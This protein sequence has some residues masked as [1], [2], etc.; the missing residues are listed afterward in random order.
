[1][2]AYEEAVSFAKS[3][4][5]KHKLFLKCSIPII[6]EMED[7][8]NPRV[9]K[10]GGKFPYL[11]DEVIPK[12]HVCDQFPMM[13]VQLY[14]PSLPEYIQDLFPENYKK[15]LLV[16]GVCPECLGSNW[17]HIRVYSED[18]LDKLVY[19]EDEGKNWAKPEYHERRNFPRIPFS[20]QPYDAYDEQRQYFHL[21]TIV[22]WK[23]T[24]MV[25]YTSLKTV[26]DLLKKEGID[27]NN[28][29][30]LVAHGINMQNNVSGNSYLGGWPHFCNGDQTPESYKILL[31]IC[32][33]EAATLGWGDCGT[34]QIW[35]GFGKNEGKFKFTCSSH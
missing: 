6:S 24:E 3:F 32:E 18:E 25:P 9:S 21:C 35:I 30:F 27:N 10:F 5:D 28:R 33:S 1:M 23:D 31:N 13:V 2:E 34:A 26:Q 19:H 17:Y 15:S 29:Y 11:E 7:D 20:P 22:D 4:I 16:L 8:C 14:V 12:C